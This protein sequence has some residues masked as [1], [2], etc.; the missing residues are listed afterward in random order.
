MKLVEFVIAS[1]GKNVAIN[2]STIQEI[3][4]NDETGDTRIFFTADELALEV[5]ETFDEVI[6]KIND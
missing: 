1:S 6:K 4:I 3:R 5:T 2:P